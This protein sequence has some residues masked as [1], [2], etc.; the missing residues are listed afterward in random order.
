MKKLL[1][2]GALVYILAAS[3]AIA[4]P[5]TIKLAHGGSTT[6]Q[7]HI[8]AEEFKRL[9]E[10]RSNKEIIVNVFPQGQLGGERDAIEGVRMGTIQMG[11]A[12]AEGPLPSFVPEMGVLI[13]PYVLQTRKQAYAVLDGPFGEEL[14][15]LISKKRLINLCFWEVGFRH[16]TTAKKA[17]NTPE[18]L[19]DLKV[20][21]QGS[22]VWLDFVKSL[23]AVPTPI[24]FGELYSALQ[25]GL[26]DGQENPIATI[27]SMRYYEV[28]KH[29]ILD[30]H[31]YSAAAVLINPGFF[32]GL[33][34]KHQ[35]IVRQAA[36]DTR[37]Y[38]RKKLEEL[39]AERLAFLEKE[40]VTIV[41]NPDIAAFAEATKDFYKSMDTVPVEMIEKFKKAAAAAK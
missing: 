33:S 24:A 6:H 30:G 32:N 10:E 13:T 28:Q 18:D 38:Q 9:V 31:T 4:A 15:A 41:K 11:I 17:I 3:V 37:D 35:D 23:G 16:F 36:L 25:Q 22:K 26:T 14:N 27:Y 39:D 40:G 21:V 1:L 5:V 12:A 34:K 2:T 20:R 19:K 8:G 29:L 7:Y